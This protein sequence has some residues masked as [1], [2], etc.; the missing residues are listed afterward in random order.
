MQTAER[1]RPPPVKVQSGQLRTAESRGTEVSGDG[2]VV[3]LGGGRCVLVSL[4]WMQGTVLEVQTERNSALL[5]DETGTFTVRGVNSIPRGKPCLSPG[6]Y[7]M[8]MGVIMAVSPEPVIRAVKMADLSELAGLHRRMWK[9]EVEE[10]QQ[11]LA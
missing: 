2:C 7:V 3:R 8:V 4:V 10:L 6:K 1:K 5:M 9:L 11:L